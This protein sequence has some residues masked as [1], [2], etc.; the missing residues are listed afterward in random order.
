M[1]HVPQHHIHLSRPHN[2]MCN[3]PPPFLLKNP[4]PHQGLINIQP[5]MQ[6]KPPQLGQY[7]NTGTSVDH[8][9]LLTSEEEVQQQTHSLYYSTPS[10]SSPTT[11]EAIPVTTRTPLIIPRPK[12]KTSLRIP[13]ISLRSNVH[14]RQARATH[15]YSLV[16]DLAQSLSSMLVLEVLQTCPTQRKSL[17]SSLGEIDLADT[18]LITFDL[19]SGE[20]HL[21][22]LISF[23]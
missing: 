5:D 18:R 13:R 2:N 10:E 9:I 1:D 6:P 21:P 20:P 17:L 3:N 22:T 16:D 4:I 23:Q 7:P 12:T 15:N 11:T 14:N 8:T 19:D